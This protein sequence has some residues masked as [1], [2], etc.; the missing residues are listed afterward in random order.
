MF[1]SQHTLHVSGD[2][3]TTS[4]GVNIIGG[5]ITS[6]SSDQTSIIVV[7]YIVNDLPNDNST[8]RVNDPPIQ[9]RDVG[10]SC[11]AD[12]MNQD[13]EIYVAIS[14]TDARG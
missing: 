3:N 10:N 2:R 13:F 8:S 12:V 4:A 9:S 1:I 6:A 5:G 11:R 14:I 7:T